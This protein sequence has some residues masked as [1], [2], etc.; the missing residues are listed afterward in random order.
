MAKQCGEYEALQ[1]QRAKEREIRAIKRELAGYQ[2]VM[3]GTDDENLLNEAHNKFDLS[4][5]NLKDKEKELQDFV[6]QTGLKRNNER[7][8]VA[9]FNKN[10]SQKAVYEVKTI[11]K[12]EENSIINLDAGANNINVF[13]KN[14]YK[15]VN[16]IEK[17]DLKNSE[18]LNAK[19]TEYRNSIVNENL[20]NA[21]LIDKDGNVFKTVGTTDAVAFPEE[22]DFTD[23]IFIHNHPKEVTNFSFSSR[24]I[25]LFIRGNLKELYG[26]DY[27][28][29]YV[30][31]KTNNIKLVDSSD[32]FEIFREWGKQRNELVELNM[33]GLL[34]E[35][36]DDIEYDY[37]NKKIAQKYKYSYERK[38]K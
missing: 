13:Q 23:S 20:E 18:Q 37:V 2:G 7:E 34:K 9:G 12:N 21:Y 15:D 22:F 17:I 11:E 3:L 1:M 8:R 10:I 27:K 19:I 36:I 6:E 31:K 24:D 33:Q 5:K 38:E 16:Y 4:S 29:S 35:N 30:L 32:E 26:D 28:F 14:Q 25:N